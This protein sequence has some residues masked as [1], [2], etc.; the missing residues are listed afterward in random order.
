MSTSSKI[1]EVIFQKVLVETTFL[2]L[3]FLANSID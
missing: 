1:Q 3:T 2:V